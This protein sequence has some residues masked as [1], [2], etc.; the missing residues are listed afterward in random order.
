MK[1]YLIISAFISFCLFVWSCNEDNNDDTNAKK[2][3]SFAQMSDMYDTGN[4]EKVKMMC[5][6]EGYSKIKDT[7]TYQNHV[8]VLGK[9]MNN[10]Y[11]LM[12]IYSVRDSLYQ[13]SHYAV[14]SDK[15]QMLD[16]YLKLAETIQ[17]SSGTEFQNSSV[18]YNDDYMYSS[19]RE[20]YH[21]Y[22]ALMSALG[23]LTEKTL[24]HCRVYYYIAKSGRTVSAEYTNNRID[25][26]GYGKD[27]KQVSDK[28]VGITLSG[29]KIAD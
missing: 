20:E 26:S 15:K 29:H 23:E 21:S 6:N 28:M 22:D 17:K 24:E 7:S 25:Y 4:P 14:S 8:C 13:L 2:V 1:K 5:R 27:L 11:Y 3:I 16:Y 18:V 9:Y 19:E 12:C 10:T